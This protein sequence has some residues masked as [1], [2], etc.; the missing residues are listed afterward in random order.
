LSLN[1]GVFL[2]LG[3]VNNRDLD[4]RVMLR[5]LPDW[6]MHDFT[7]ASECANRIADADV[8]ISN[9][10]RIDRRALSGATALKLIAVAAT[11][12]NNIDL[13]A[14]REFGV[15]VCNSRDYATESLTQHAITLILCLLGGLPFYRDRVRAGAWSAQD[16]F[17]LFDR[18]IREAAGLNLGI[19]GYGVLGRSVAARAKALGM[20]VMVAERR[21]Y[22]PRGDH[23]PF[24]DVVAHSDVISIHCPLNDE[25]HGLF[26]RSVMERMKPEAILINTARGG[27]VDERDLAACLREGIIGGAGIDVLTSE[28]PQQDHPLLAYDI[29]NLI[30]TPHNAWASRMARQALVQQLARIISAFEK[31]QP[32][33]RVA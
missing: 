9:K 12:T 29:P 19:V 11:G 22:S 25:T 21:G 33:N 16:Q 4:L 24:E 23:L 27:I 6:Q 18:P 31:G 26:D 2:D 28:P 15:A 8:V 10:C 17:S 20:N 13:E 1:R 30:V 5:S 14:A 7:P 32:L 3:S